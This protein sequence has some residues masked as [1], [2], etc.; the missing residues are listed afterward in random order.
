M[1]RIKKELFKVIDISGFHAKW[2]PLLRYPLA[3]GIA[4]IA[5]LFRFLL[6]P[7][8]AGLA[9]LTFYPAIVIS[10]YLCGIR[11]GIV[12]VLLSA[13]TSFY[14]FEPP[15]IAVIIFLFSAGLIGFVVRQMQRYAKQFQGILTALQQNELSYQSFLEDQTEVIC[16]F[17]ADGTILYV[18]AAFCRWFGVQRESLVGQ[19]WHPV[20]WRDD[21]P[22]INEKLDTLSPE[23]PVVSIENRV[24][25]AGGTMRWGQFVNRAFFDKE[26]Q[27]IETQAVARDITDRKLIEQAVKNI[28][29]KNEALLSAASDGVHILDKKGNIVQFSASFAK[30]LGYTHEE[31]ALLNVVD[32]DAQIPANQ[33][34]DSVI[35]RIKQPAT[36]ETK[37]R[38]KDGSIIDVEI[39]A[40][41]VEFAGK[42][43]LYASSRDI[44]ERKSLEAKLAESAKEIEDL[45]DNAPCGYHSVGPDGYYLRINA[46]ELNWLGCT[47]E[48]VVGKM[49]PTDFFTPDSKELFNR[50]FPGFLK[51][52]YIDN[53]TFSLICKDNTTK[54]VNLTAI[55]VKD[56][57]GNFLNSRSVFYD[58]TELN[59][60]QKQRHRLMLEQQAM[61][62]TNLIGM[63][64]LQNRRI[65][66]NN[67]KFEQLF[68]YEPGEMIGQFTRL[69]YTDESAYQDAADTAY[70]ALLKEG[71]YR[72]QREMVRKD[73][74]KIWMDVNGTLLSDTDNSESLW[75]LSDITSI[76]RHEEQIEH[77]A[78]HDILTGLPNRLLVSDRLNQAL[79]QAERAEQLLV[80]C[81]LDLD[82]F[83][84]INDTFGHHAGDRLLVEIAKRMEESVR[85]HDTVGRLGGDEFVIL[86]IN[87]KDIG[88]YQIVLQRVIDA[89]NEPIELD[90]VNT[91]KVGASIGITI[92]PAD[93]SDPDTLLR[94]ADQAMYQAKKLGRN[95]INIFAPD[96]G[97]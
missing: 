58:I 88:E 56:A 28:S 77:I 35:Q 14:F 94:H 30:M 73:G 85:T 68:G 42:R 11:P 83:K 25:T 39:N 61:L 95:R 20:V 97:A 41:E 16:R 66:W 4:L 79:A 86:L 52:G 62:N 57:D 43:Y 5:T 10:F 49:K 59:K 33:L 72:T 26:G 6:L 31:T 78:Y 29:Q 37:H 90:A 24:I 15:F 12:T 96:D 36:F 80:V 38:R 89:I 21:I 32:W 46:T 53:L 48:D 19:K 87:I 51:N 22:L 82:G 45:Y 1:T 93:K 54:H 9:F 65:V 2:S 34:I 76:K 84:L 7:V 74:E 44:T 92:F 47:R 23:N 55:A 63:V 70:P 50:S 91:V 27:L 69:M 18:N 60:S 8:E 40:K 3:V 81:Y 64:K 67:Q 13:A 17:K 71:I 75:M